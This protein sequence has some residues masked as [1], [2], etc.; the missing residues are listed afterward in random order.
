MLGAIKM[1]RLLV[2]ISLLSS[3]IS[4]GQNDPW[5]KLTAISKG[6]CEIELELKFDAK[7]GKFGYTDSTETYV[8][9]PQFYCATQFINCIALTSKKKNCQSE[10]DINKVKWFYINKTNEIVIPP[11]IDSRTKWE[12]EIKTGPNKTYKQ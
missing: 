10:I 4:Y 5:D 11:R 9:Y 12:N 3:L 8:I 1:K 2:I 7:V 6:I